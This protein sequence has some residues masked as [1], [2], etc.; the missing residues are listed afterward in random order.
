[1]ARKWER[2][3]SP[4]HCLTTNK[5]TLNLF[6]HRH[7]SPNMSMDEPWGSKS[8]FLSPFKSLITKLIL[9]S[10]V[11]FTLHFHKA[12]WTLLLSF[13]CVLVLFVFFIDCFKRR[14]GISL[15]IWTFYGFQFDLMSVVLFGK[16]HLLACCV[17]NILTLSMKYHWILLKNNCC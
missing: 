12:M 16:K 13:Q 11:C 1:M 4:L 6:Y 9:M 15:E 14:S 7:H 8:D 3:I 2:R 5:Q 17:F 10:Y